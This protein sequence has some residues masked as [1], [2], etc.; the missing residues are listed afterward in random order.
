[1]KRREY[2]VDVLG[3]KNGREVEHDVRVEDGE[4]FS[5]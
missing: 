4:L 3:E 5:E 1:M 2:G